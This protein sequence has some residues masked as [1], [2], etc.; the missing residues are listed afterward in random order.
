MDAFLSMVWLYLNFFKRCAHIHAEN[1]HL[2]NLPSPGN[3]ED[4]GYR[5]VLVAGQIIP[6]LTSNQRFMFGNPSFST[7]APSWTAGASGNCVVV[8]ARWLI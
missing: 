8:L 4:V 6:G 3:E 7:H 1:P 5:A 2:N